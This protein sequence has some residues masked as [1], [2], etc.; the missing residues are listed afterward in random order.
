[1]RYILVLLTVSSHQLQCCCSE[2]EQLNHSC[3]MA[4]GTLREEN[5]SFK[6]GVGRSAQGLKEHGTALFWSL[7]H[8]IDHGMNML[9]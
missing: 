3:K 8:L 4:R 2:A 7:D 5:Q 6:I 9:L 1:M